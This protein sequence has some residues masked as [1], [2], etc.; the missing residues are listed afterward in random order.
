MWA[1]LFA[2]AVTLLSSCK[3][4]SSILPHNN[5]DTIVIYQKDTLLTAGSVPA[6]LQCGFSKN[7]PLLNSNKLITLLVLEKPEIVAS[8][9]GT[10]DIYITE[11]PLNNKVSAAHSGFVNVLDTYSLT[12]SD[13]KKEAT[14]NISEAVQT[15]FAQKKNISSLYLTIRF[16][17]IKL[18]DG[19]YATNGGQLHISGVKILQIQK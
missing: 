6:V 4:S 16:G 13:A 8:P 3:T 9:E 19:T 12:A 5:T 7:S 15:L 1:I 18:A 11:E 2:G 14:V 10:Y 17:P